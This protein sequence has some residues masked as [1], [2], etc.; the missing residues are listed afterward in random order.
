MCN[1]YGVKHI[2]EKD[3]GHRRRE[4]ARVVRRARHPGV[5]METNDF[6]RDLNVP[7]RGYTCS[8]PVVNESGSLKI[9]WALELCVPHTA[10][11]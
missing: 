7:V 11:K 3:I 4:H 9:F 5:L 8:I 6:G 2:Y 10:E 1:R